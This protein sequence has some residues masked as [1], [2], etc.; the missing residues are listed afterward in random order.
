MLEKIL[1]GLF[2]IVVLNTFWSPL[3]ETASKF[4]KDYEKFSSELFKDVADYSTATFSDYY[5][6]LVSRRSE[7][8]LGQKKVFLLILPDL[9]E[10]DSMCSCC[11]PENLIDSQHHEG[12]F[13]FLAQILAKEENVEQVPYFEVSG[14]KESYPPLKFADTS[15]VRYFK[16]RYSLDLNEQMTYSS[17][18]VKFIDG[19]VGRRCVLKSKES[20]YTFIFYM[21]YV[22]VTPA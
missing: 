7:K 10:S 3:V 19:V 20:D 9:D 15:F 4:V 2:A 17:P 12:F 14:H 6:D 18:L 21:R 8:N 22:N 16:V 11:T 5:F 13:Q 1:A